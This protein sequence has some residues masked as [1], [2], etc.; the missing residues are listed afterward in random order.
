[1]N[2]MGFWGFGVWGFG[3][4][5]LSLRLASSGLQPSCHRLIPSWFGLDSALDSIGLP[6]GRNPVVSPSCL[7]V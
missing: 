6:E 3:E 4:S 2:A 1:M 5:L 7:D